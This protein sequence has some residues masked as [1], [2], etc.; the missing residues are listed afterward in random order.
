M[1]RGFIHRDI[2]AQNILLN[3]HKIIQIIDHASVFPYIRDNSIDRILLHI[4]RNS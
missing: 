3:I 1:E 2:K 4:R